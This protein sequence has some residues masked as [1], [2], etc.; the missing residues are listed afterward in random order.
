MSD[1]GTSA[2]LSP[3][4]PSPT[5]NG[6]NRSAERAVA[7]RVRRAV[8]VGVLS[9]LVALADAGGVGRQL[10]TIVAP[11]GRGGRDRAM[12]VRFRA[13]GAGT[14]LVVTYAQSASGCA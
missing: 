8:C 4:P 13:L 11:Y 1:F 10:W 14:L 12:T 6:R 5:R 7:I 9:V 3:L 2:N